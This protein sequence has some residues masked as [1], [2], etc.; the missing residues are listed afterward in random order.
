MILEC[1]SCHARFKV[2]DGAIP[3]AGRIVRC[4]KCAHEWHVDPAAAAPPIPKEEPPKDI[5]PEIPVI[6]PTSDLTFEEP[7]VDFSAEAR[8]ADEDFLSQLEAAIS[9]SEAK[10]EPRAARPA[11]RPAAVTPKR[12]P[13]N[14]KPFKIAV[15]VLMVAWLVLA[16]I[17][18]FPKWMNAPVLS[19]IYHAL[20]INATDGLLFADVTMEREHEEG[21]KTK[22]ILAGTI[23]NH[24][25]ATRA[26]PTV[27]VELRD[28]KGG[29]VWSHNYPVNAELK[30][31]EVY[32]F[33]IGNVE[34]MF[35]SNVN[36]IKVDMGNTL[37][38]MV[39]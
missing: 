30:A 17:A 5:P 39:R 26:V 2:P 21:G 25:N 33:R 3:E 11:K 6:L 8:V 9:A 24:S 12:K 7:E 18:Y 19:G 23:K 34:T 31:G 29:T 1:P 13:I 37:Q 27:R 22:F 4:S 16:F 28:A 32:P 20:G 10:A 15:P 36:V 38:L 35:A 14:P